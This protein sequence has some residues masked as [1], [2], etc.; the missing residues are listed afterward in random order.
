MAL[1][2]YLEVQLTRDRFDK[3]LV[4]V[5]S[6]L[7]NGLEASP[8]HLRALAAALN[9]AADDA[10]AQQTKGPHFTPTKREYQL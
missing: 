6:A 8:D 7:G 5:E 1:P 3:P 9:R 4:V 10:E 2:K